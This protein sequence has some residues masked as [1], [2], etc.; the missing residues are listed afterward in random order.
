[1]L[2]FIFHSCRRLVL[3]QSVLLQQGSSSL[4]SVDCRKPE[5]QKFHEVSQ[6][7]R[8]LSQIGVFL[9]SWDQAHKVHHSNRS[10]GAKRFSGHVVSEL[11]A[12]PC[13][14]LML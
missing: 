5:L 8:T 2:G 6:K 1:M 12:D 13:A 3:L 9:T 4:F 11:L 7:R 14:V 10:C